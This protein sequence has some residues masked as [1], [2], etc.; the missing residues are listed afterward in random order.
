MDVAFADTGKGSCRVPSSW[1][2]Q[3]RNAAGDRVEVRSHI[4][5]DKDK[6]CDA[7]FGRPADHNERDTADR[8]RATERLRGHFRREIS[9]KARSGLFTS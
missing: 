3:T 9:L 5:G 1:E 8:T 6:R 2:I 7:T 4:S